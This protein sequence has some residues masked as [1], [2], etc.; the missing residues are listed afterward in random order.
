[1]FS[2]LGKLAAVVAIAALFAAAGPPVR[3][4]AQE[5]PLNII[6][7]THGAASDSFRTPVK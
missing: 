6:M 5:K 2:Q 4:Q 1:M 3:I 7:I